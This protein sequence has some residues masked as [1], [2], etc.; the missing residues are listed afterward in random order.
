MLT[1]GPC[2]FSLPDNWETD[3][4]GTEHGNQEQSKSKTARGI[5]RG[6]SQEA[7]VRLAYFP[8]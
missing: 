8:V 1:L 3:R 2:P 7:K 5:K 4:A 6:A